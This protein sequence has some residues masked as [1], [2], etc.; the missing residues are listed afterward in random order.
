MPRGLIYWGV[1][2]D[3]GVFDEPTL[4]IAASKI[5]NGAGGY[6]NPNKW[7]QTASS[8]TPPWSN[9]TSFTAV[10]LNCDDPYPPYDKGLDVF[11]CIGWFKGKTK[12]T[13]VS[14]FIGTGI[15][16]CVSCKEM[17]SGC[18]NLE[19]V[20]GLDFFNINSIDMS[21]M[22][23]NCSK[24][25]SL[26][27]SFT[28]TDMNKVTNTS[29]MFYNCSQFEFCAEY[30][31]PQMDVYA[32]W[33]GFYH[34]NNTKSLLTNTSY[35]F[36]GCSK[37]AD[38]P[39]WSQGER[40]DYKYAH[41]NTFNLDVS[42]VTNMSHMFENC[43]ALQG[44]ET[45]QYIWGFDTSSAIDMSYMFKGCSN[46]WD[47]YSVIDD[48]WVKFNF[49]KAKN[50]SHMFEGI[51]V[52]TSADV[53][54]IQW[55]IFTFLD[56]SSIENF[57]YMFADSAL[58]ELPDFSPW[59]RGSVKQLFTNAKDMSYMF[60]GCTKLIAA[61]IPHWYTPNVTNMSYMFSGCTSLLFADIPSFII[62]NVTNTTSMFQN[63]SK[64]K[65]IFTKSSA[66]WNN[67]SKLS[68]SGNMF[69]G[70]TSLVGGNG[71]TYS[72]S[73]V[74]KAYAR[75]DKAGQAGYFSIS[76]R[77]V[78]AS[79][80]IEHGTVLNTG[81]YEYGDIVRIG[82]KPD[83]DYYKDIVEIDQN[84][85]YFI[86]DEID[87]INVSYYEIELQYYSYEWVYPKEGETEYRIGPAP[88][89]VVQA[90]FL[91]R[92][93]YNLSILQPTTEYE[94]LGAGSYKY[95]DT[96]VLIVDMN[97]ASLS[98]SGWY[99]RSGNLISTANPYS[100]SMPDSDYT[101]VARFTDSPFEDIN[102]RQFI[103]TNGNGEL[104]KLAAK[105][106]KPFLDITDGLGFAKKLTMITI[107]NSEEIQYEKVEMPKPKGT[108]YFYN[109]TNSNIYKKYNDFIR[110]VMVKPLTLWYKVPIDVSD[111]TNTTY[112]IPVEITD[113]GKIDIDEKT[114]A[115]ICPIN[116]YGLGFWKET[117]ISVEQTS[118][119]ISIYND[120]DFEC[121]VELTISKE[122]GTAFDNPEI[123][124]KNG[125]TVYGKCKIGGTY[126]RVILNTVNKEEAIEL[127][128]GEIL[129][130]D[131]FNF[132]DF[133]AADGLSQFPFPKLQNG[134]ITTIEFTYDNAQS[135]DNKN[136]VVVYDKEYISV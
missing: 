40:I 58:I 6:L 53:G 93:T 117:K 9:N 99:D 83:N 33:D 4:Y 112:H 46:L 18:T 111:S 100:F 125:N 29:Y 86:R 65:K 69:S 97:E 128:S 64:L 80:T 106:E 114:N 102:Y 23:Y 51:G 127:Y 43:T 98:F 48:D 116:F 35:M 123:V 68:S 88:S 52:A 3:T 25:K 10:A 50:V 59:N 108:L 21:N 8:T 136:Y 56:L 57:S 63:C 20:Q 90:E 27:N 120:G 41:K 118:T 101:L 110:F 105:N 15:S 60:K 7:E 49:K 12:I 45:C 132:I 61:K 124:F 77:K 129:V 71:T 39:I 67:S 19:W 78:I 36:Y 28:I 121:G 87:T 30:D 126:N 92:N 91:Y 13:K 70:C 47:M 96:P 26:S 31:D 54:A 24:L 134:V 82:V 119:N 72:S 14:N 55:K 34:T 115:L 1:S 11:N 130:E 135:S 42:N 16:N 22:F 109:D 113:I 73:N 95:L 38:G 76:E 122:D 89:V 84:D 79:E 103:I 5:D 85:Y 44:N 94:I 104:F 17:F 133:S 62:D 74:N 131:S 2:S 32:G 75:I 107:G 66:N 37:L 81:T